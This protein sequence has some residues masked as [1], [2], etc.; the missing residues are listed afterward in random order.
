MRINSLF[1]F[2]VAF[3]LMLF[4]PSTHLLFFAPYLILCLYKSSMRAILW[5]SVACGAILDLFSSSPHFGLTAVNYTLTAVLLYPQRLNFF[6]DKISTLPL[7]T[8]FFSLLSTLLHLLLLLCVGHPRSLHFHMIFTDFI[9]MPIADG[10]YALLCFTLPA[11]SY[12]FTKKSL[13][14]LKQQR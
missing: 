2:L 12:H 4:I 5:N 13:Q 3:T 11:H 7:M 6:V 9:A 10:L 14:K 1:A 8:S